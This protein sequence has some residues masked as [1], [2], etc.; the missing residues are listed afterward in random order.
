M[1]IQ[2]VCAIVLEM[3]SY[4]NESGIKLL[5]FNQKQKNLTPL[6]KKREKQTT[7]IMLTYANASSSI[8]LLAELGHLTFL[9]GVNQTHCSQHAHCVWSGL[10]YHKWAI[11]TNQGAINYL[12]YIANVRW[13]EIVPIIS[14]RLQPF[15]IIYILWVYIS[16]AALGV[17]QCQTALLSPERS[18]ILCREVWSGGQ[19]GWFR[20]K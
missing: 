1:F 14:M 17:S 6:I 18:V 13:N 3:S 7:G 12:V 5:F 19:D 20:C 8:S 11:S 16:A 15:K 4:A 10:Q 2:K 9:P